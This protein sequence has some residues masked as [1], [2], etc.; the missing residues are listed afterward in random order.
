[1]V[2]SKLKNYLRITNKK[3]PERARQGTKWNFIK[4]HN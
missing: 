3:Q 4:K 1:M 2:R